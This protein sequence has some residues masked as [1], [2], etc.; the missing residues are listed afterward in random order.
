MRRASAVTWALGIAEFSIGYRLDVS[1]WS[2][3]DDLVDQSFI[4]VV[5]M[6][7]YPL[8]FVV[9][10]DCFSDLCCGEC[11]W[12]KGSKRGAGGKRDDGAAL[13]MIA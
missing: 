4:G 1:V 6:L 2:D 3:G 8:L 13:M 7:K 12:N 10:V 5:V 11:C 9:L